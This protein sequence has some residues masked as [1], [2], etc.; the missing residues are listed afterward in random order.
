M[1]AEAEDDVL[2][3]LPLAPLIAVIWYSGSTHEGQQSA[4]MCVVSR[5]PVGKTDRGQ[6]RRRA[7]FPRFH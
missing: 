2:G 7:G 1:L 4:I 3:G 6:R 5:L